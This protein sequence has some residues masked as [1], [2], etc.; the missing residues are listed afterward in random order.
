MKSGSC[1]RQTERL[2]FWVKVAPGL[3]KQIHV[4]QDMGFGFK[5][6]AYTIGLVV[7]WIGRGGLA[8]VVRGAD[9]FP[10]KLINWGHFG[11]SGGMW[12]VGFPGF[13]I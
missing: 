13:R 11:L 5:R 1:R 10:R 9:L 4:G 2:S 12:E 8:L 6:S 3:R 7:D